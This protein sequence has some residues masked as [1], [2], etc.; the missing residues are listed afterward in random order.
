MNVRANTGV[1]C[2]CCGSE[3]GVGG[4]GEGVEE[5]RGGMWG[6]RG[7]RRGRGGENYEGRRRR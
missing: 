3:E 7:R 5:G 6:E 4:K 2:C 1:P